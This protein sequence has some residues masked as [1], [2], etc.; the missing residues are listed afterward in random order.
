MNEEEN[1]VLQ[2]KS[3]GQNVWIGLQHNKYEW[4]DKSC[5]TYRSK[6]KQDP[7]NSED[8]IS[9]TADGIPF[10]FNPAQCNT[11]NAVICSKG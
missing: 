9:L 5:S 7:E 4:A 3:Q 6:F 10:F 1:K 2:E 8:C 11:E